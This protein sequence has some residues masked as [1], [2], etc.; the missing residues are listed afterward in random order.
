MSPGVD[1]IQA[2]ILKYGGEA[3]REQVYRLVRD[4][5]INE[6]TPEEWSTTVL[7]PIHKKGDKLTCENYKGIALL[8]LQCVKYYL[9]PLIED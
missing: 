5:W 8:S 7:C 4:I 9:L 1:E 2:E 6:R 3:V